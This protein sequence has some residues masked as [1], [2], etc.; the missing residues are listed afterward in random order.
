[1]LP[2]GMQQVLDDHS[3]KVQMMSQIMASTD[4]N[5]PQNDHGSKEPRGDAEMTL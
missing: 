3:R 5:L 2:A 4:N 1:M